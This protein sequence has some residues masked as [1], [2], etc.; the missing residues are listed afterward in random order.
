MTVGDDPPCFASIGLGLWNYMFT[1]PLPRNT[2]LTLPSEEAAT[3]AT[4][5]AEEEEEED[6]ENVWEW[7]YPAGAAAATDSDDDYYDAH[8]DDDDENDTRYRTIPTGKVVDVEA[9]TKQRERVEEDEAIQERIIRRTE[10]EDEEDDTY[11]YNE[12]S[13]ECSELEGAKSSNGE[14]L[15]DNWLE[16]KDDESNIMRECPTTY[17]EE[18]DGATHER[19]NTACVRRENAAPELETIIGSRREAGGEFGASSS[20]VVQDDNE[21]ETAAAAAAKAAAE[22]ER[23]RGVVLDHQA[24]LAELEAERDRQAVV[25]EPGFR[26]RAGEADENDGKRTERSADEGE[27]YRLRG[28]V[29]SQRAEIESL[30]QSSAEEAKEAEKEASTAAAEIERLRGVVLAHQAELAELEAE[31]DR[32]AASELDL[33]RRTGETDAKA[34]SLEEENAT[35]RE[36]VRELEQSSGVSSSQQQQQQQEEIE[37]LRRRVVSHQEELTELEIEHDRALLWAREM[38]ER[39]EAREAALRRMED[40]RKEEEGRTRAAEEEARLS[41]EK[42]KELEGKWRESTARAEQAQ[43]ERDALKQRVQQLELGLREE[44]RQDRTTSPSPSAEDETCHPS[45]E[46]IRT[47]EERIHILTEQLEEQ[48][49]LHAKEKQALQSQ[50]LKFMRSSSPSDEKENDATNTAGT[51]GTTDGGEQAGTKRQRNSPLGAR[52]RS[53]NVSANGINAGR[54]GGGKSSFHGPHSD[55]KRRRVPPKRGDYGPAREKRTPPPSPERSSDG[56]SSP[57]SIFEGP[58]ATT[59]YDILG[60]G[61]GATEA[62]IK[63]AYRK[64]ALRH[65]PDKKV[66]QQGGDAGGGGGYGN[67]ESSSANDTDT[68]DDPNRMFRLITEAYR[69]LGDEAERRRYNALIR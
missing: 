65:H 61:R 1:T 64:L 10:A 24:E 50:L 52:P 35:L 62:E 29:E 66:Q 47:M 51:E 39:E 48:R 46:K 28:L 20:S 42:T 13:F 68:D 54:A 27:M 38:E 45:E 44:E 17:A 25:A 21:N 41:R 6:G 36:R 60:V 63:R 43:Q 49:V 55:E 33:R 30:R 19:E 40:L 15:D 23:L 56:A 3:T 16:E 57:K 22:I 18:T 31:E 53:G 14:D 59:H 11:D 58:G 7:S 2:T 9:E 32:R 5:K 37:R 4:E 34:A 69:V 26:R 12:E 8:D 67:G